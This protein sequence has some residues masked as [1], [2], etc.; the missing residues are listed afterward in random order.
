MQSAH[1]TFGHRVL[2]FVSYDS[3]ERQIVTETIAEFGFRAS[4][5]PFQRIA[6]MIGITVLLLTTRFLSL[7]IQLLL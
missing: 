4:F 3:T 5:A 2:R 1:P 6:T 7:L